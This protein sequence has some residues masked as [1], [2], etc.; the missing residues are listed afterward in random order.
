[1]GSG[2]A[3]GPAFERLSTRVRAFG[4][5]LALTLGVA[6]A[7]AQ[8][9]EPPEA[10][11]ASAV[12]VATRAEAAHY[13]SEGERG[14]YEGLALG[15]S[16]RF[17]VLRVRASLPYYRLL[18]PAGPV[19]GFGDLE[20][21]VEVAV[22]EGGEWSFGGAF[23]A[24]LPTGSAEK[25]LGMGHVMLGPSAWLS[26]RSEAVFASA[27][28]GF[29]GALDREDQDAAMPAHHA[30]HAGASANA[31][32][33]PGG[34]IPNPMNA[35][36]LWVGASASYEP[37]RGVRLDAGGTVAAPTSEQGETRATLRAGVE[38][39]AGEV[40]ASLGFEID[41]LGVTRREVA[42]ASVGWRF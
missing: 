5:A 15:A 17:A 18:G 25:R 9:C 31:H 38:L 35:N 39:L 7:V 29:M 4:V 30:H 22:L 20:S 19:N 32:H 40:D 6:P 12:S 11:D 2:S 1:M 41:V 26:G 28:L 23:A 10:P 37:A 13:E 8:H 24:T 33:A 3:R 42:V 34:P 27:E 14:L 16:I 36:E 21:E